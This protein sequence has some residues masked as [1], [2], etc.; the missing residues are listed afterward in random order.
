MDRSRTGASRRDALKM[1]GLASIA[2][3]IGP[4]MIP[5]IARAQ[6]AGNPVVDAGS[7]SGVESR[8]GQSPLLT[9]VSRHLQWTSAEEGLAVAA[10]AGFPAIAWTV[11]PGAHIDPVD[12]RR[13]LPR[14]VE[15]TR[16]AGLATPMII[17]QI[18]DRDAPNAEAILDTMSG[19]GISRYRAGSQRYDLTRPIE[20]Q[21]DAFRSKL[22]G[23][24]QL[25]EKYGATAMLH[26]HSR[27]HQIGGSGWDMWLAVRDID[28]TFVGINF[29]VGHV[30]A[31]GGEGLLE[32]LRAARPYVHAISLKDLVWRRSPEPEP[33]RWPWETH[34]VP[35]G[36]GM[37]NFRDIFSYLAE[38][39][40]NGPLEMYYEYEVPVPGSDEPM[41]MLGTNYGQWQLELPRSQFL[42]YLQRDVGFYRAIMRETGLSA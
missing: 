41:D 17:T 32:S 33:G 27:G 28:P 22:E 30:T 14:V 23:L 29:D 9:L 13:E 40:F 7:A 31:K 37:V 2:P 35:P 42:A 34:F 4:A 38:S 16:A 25:N 36:E 12:V 26:T 3:L 1:V 8:Q 11:R 15:M 10:E 20:P 19:L 21:L 24:A 18:G 39:S 6:T 5:V